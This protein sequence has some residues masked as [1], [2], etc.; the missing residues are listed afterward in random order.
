M[1]ECGVFF[2]FFPLFILPP[3]EP[4]LQFITDLASGKVALRRNE[5]QGC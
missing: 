4:Y 3:R 5:I 1:S 2:F